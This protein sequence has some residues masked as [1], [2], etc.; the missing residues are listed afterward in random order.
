[1]KLTFNERS[2]VIRPWTVRQHRLIHSQDALLCMEPAFCRTLCNELD[3]TAMSTRICPVIF[4]DGSAGIF[5]LSDYCHDDQTLALLDLLQ[6]R[7]F[8]L[9]EPSLFVLSPALMIALDRLVAAPTLQAAGVLRSSITEQSALSAAF[10]DLVQWGLKHG[11]SDIHLNVQRARLDSSVYFTIA[12]RYVCPDRYRKIPTATLLEMLAV[13]W[14]SVQGGNGAVFDP[15]IEQQ[16]RLQVNVSDQ[17]VTLRW[18]SLATDAGPSVCLRILVSEQDHL[19]PNL[20]S[21]GY[22]PSQVDALHR[23]RAEQGGA[24]I[25]SGVVGSGKSTT[26]ATL[27]REIPA[28]RK[29]ITLEDP[30]EYLIPNALQNT[31]CHTL[32]EKDDASFD[33]KLKTIKRS[34]M[35]DLLIGEIRDAA[36]GR[37]FMDLAGCGVNLYTTVHAGSALLIV[38]RLSSSFIG[39]ARDLLSTPG[40]LKLLVYQCLMARLCAYCALDVRQVIA[41]GC[42][43]CANGIMRDCNWFKQWLNTVERVLDVRADGLRFRREAGCE[44]CLTGNISSLNGTQ[45]RTVVAEMIEPVTESEFLDGIKRHDGIGLY[46]WFHARPRSHFSDPDMSGK[47]AM[48]CALYKMSQGL[49]DPR[50][51]ESK[52]GSFELITKGNRPRV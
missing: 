2:P 35:N 44:H 39:V 21:L 51:I 45:G 23:A 14:M 8:K 37:A 47:T 48:Q 9:N 31:I 12:G 33:T 52:F 6:A 13:A 34:A 7:G 41:A 17:R 16:G 20:L 4:T 30:A 29:V 24:V 32:D 28:D 50:Q 5:V 25:L 36:G 43:R 27:M 38:D 15:M 10:N 19:T 49:I 22:L 42:W 46:E 11:A 40:I 3:V 18:A 1:M 26:I